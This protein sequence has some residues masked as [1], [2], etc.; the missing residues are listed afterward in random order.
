MRKQKHVIFIE[1][2]SQ[3]IKTHVQEWSTTLFF[4]DWIYSQRFTSVVLSKRERERKREREMKST[5][6][7]WKNSWHALSR[8]G[9]NPRHSSA[10]QKNSPSLKKAC[11]AIICQEAFARNQ[12][13]LFYTEGENSCN[14]WSQNYSSLLSGHYKKKKNSTTLKATAVHFGRERKIG[15]MMKP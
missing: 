12:S 5:S 10:Q 9:E 1:M 14:F 3:Y 4:Q 2:L 8:P 6:M 7:H 13:V 15:G 11:C